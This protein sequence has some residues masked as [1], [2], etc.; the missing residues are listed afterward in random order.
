[1]GHS[2]KVPYVSLFRRRRA[3]APN[4]DS[5]VPR[6]TAHGVGHT[7]HH[8]RASYALMAFRQSI[9]TLVARR[10]LIDGSGPAA[11]Q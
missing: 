2:L 5:D 6:L 3:G 11:H 8:D 10:G 7:Q 9:I 4:I 1:V